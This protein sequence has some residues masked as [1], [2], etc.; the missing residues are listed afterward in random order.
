MASNTAMTAARPTNIFRSFKL[1]SGLIDK[2]DAAV[3]AGSLAP[4]ALQPLLGDNR[5]HEQ[6]GDRMGHGA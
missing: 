1:R 2:L 5:H 3:G 4:D 6:R